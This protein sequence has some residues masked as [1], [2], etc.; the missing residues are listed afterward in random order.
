MEY[1]MSHDMQLH[2][3]QE[4][5]AGM[6]TCYVPMVRRGAMALAAGMPQ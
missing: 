4:M 3:T 5:V 6:T 2:N 1:D